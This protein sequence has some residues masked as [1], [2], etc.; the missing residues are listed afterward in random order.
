[1]KRRVAIG[2]HFIFNSAPC[3]D[4]YRDGNI[5]VTK[6]ISHELP[7]LERGHTG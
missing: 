4:S 1:M 3:P 6:S 7:T 2:T 5:Q